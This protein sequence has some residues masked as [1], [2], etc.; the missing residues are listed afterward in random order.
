MGLF[1]KAKKLAE[2]HADTVSD[3]LDKVADVVD[4]KTGGKH[5]DKI[6]SGTEKVKEFLGGDEAAGQPPPAQP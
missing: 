1:D 6:A 2:D 3:A 5:T 4:E